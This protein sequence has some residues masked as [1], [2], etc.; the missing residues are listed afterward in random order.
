MLGDF[1]PSKKEPETVKSSN[2]SNINYNTDPDSVCQICGKPSK[3]IMFATYLCD[4]EECLNKA[5]DARG[6]PG[7]HKKDPKRWMDENK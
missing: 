4:S 5:Y 3:R 1:I 2:N 6:G 7:G